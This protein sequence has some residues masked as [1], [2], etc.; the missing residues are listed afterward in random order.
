MI[1]H[2]TA[3]GK[4]YPFK[5]GYRAKQ[6]LKEHYRMEGKNLEDPD[7]HDLAY[8]SMYGG[9]VSESIPVDFTHEEVLAWCDED[10]KFMEQLVKIVEKIYE[11]IIEQ[12]RLS[13][14]LPDEEK[15]T[16][17]RSQRRKSMKAV[18]K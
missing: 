14:G 6:M 15:K 10:E 18:K 3:R 5:F 16:T 11:P 2:I 4:T 9:C 12:M 8:F 1:Y 17:N 13:M 7:L